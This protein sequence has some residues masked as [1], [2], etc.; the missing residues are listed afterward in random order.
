MLAAGKRL[1]GLVRKAAKDLEGRDIARIWQWPEAVALQREAQQCPQCRGW[2][3]G[4]A[5]LYRE[6]NGCDFFGYTREARAILIECKEANKP[7][8]DIG[9]KGLKPHQLIALRDGH[10]AGAIALLVWRRG[11]EIAVLDPDMIEMFSAGRKSI[12]WNAVPERFV[13]QASA[14]PGTL[15]WPWLG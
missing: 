8:L 3:E 1:E 13:K 7:R 12:P 4:F 5:L 15:L 11:D 10:R 14:E 2:N 6:K 9:E